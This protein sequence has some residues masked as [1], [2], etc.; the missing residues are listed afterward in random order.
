MTA[1]ARLAAIHRQTG[2]AGGSDGVVQSILAA[3][4]QP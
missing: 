3:A 4:S 2:L 1:G